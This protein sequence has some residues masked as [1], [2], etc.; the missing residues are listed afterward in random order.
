MSQKEGYE[1]LV[2]VTSL[3]LASA[4][5]AEAAA[6]VRLVECRIEVVRAF[7]TLLEQLRDAEERLL[8]A[9]YQR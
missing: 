5:G 3:D 1:A 9:G 7:N 8:M 2:E 6:K 4:I